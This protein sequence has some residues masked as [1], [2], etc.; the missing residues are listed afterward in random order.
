MRKLVKAK[1]IFDGKED[2]L[3][4]NRIML[5]EDGLISSIGYEEDFGC[6]CD[7]IEMIDLSD[8][9]IIPGLIDCHTH[10][11]IVPQQGNQV[12]Q[13]KLPAPQNILRSI[14]HM[15]EDFKSGVTT[16]RIMGE[17]NY[18][19]IEIKK[20][21]KEK[22]INGPRIL[23]AGKGIVATNG[24]GVALTVADGPEEVRK[25]AREN[26]YKGADH[27]KI[28]VTGGISTLGNSLNNATYS[29]DEIKMAVEEAE[30]VGT[31]VAAHAHGGIGIDL[32]IEGGVRSIEHAALI[33]EEQ[34]E[35]VI[36]AD[37]WITI[38][39]TI[40]FDE[41][42]VEAKDT[43]NEDINKKLVTGRKLAKDNW[44]KVV[45]SG[46]NYVVGT[47]S[48]HG[49]IADEIKFLTS[50]GVPNIDA[51]KAA[52]SKAAKACNFDKV[53]VLEPGMF[54]DFLALEGNP[55]EDIDV[56]KK[57]KYIYISGELVE[58]YI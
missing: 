22:L 18:I 15:K 41:K 43:V 13:M 6:L 25:L 51:I 48:M 56:L 40:L 57:I 1:G 36:K 9:Y 52:T 45:L 21:I 16:M 20:A 53:G 10:L 7:E 35:K 11:S 50:L 5:V 46:A 17:E 33:T 47:D 39:S 34:I 44:R 29:I 24:H 42:G 3:L 12:E 2:R 55:L 30:R 8:Y 37:A 32:C 27:L 19:D 26:L 28:F 49:M 31:Y 54:A 4:Y 58:E 38:T 14:S 23:A